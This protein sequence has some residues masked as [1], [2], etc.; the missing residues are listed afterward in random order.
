MSDRTTTGRTARAGHRAGRPT[1]RPVGRS[2]GQSGTGRGAGPAGNSPWAG[3]REKWRRLL[4]SPQ[5][6]YK[7]ILLVTGL[8]VVIGLIVALSSSMVT[9]R[10]QEGGTVF[11]EFV[12]QARMVLIGLVVMWGALWVRP[13]KVRTWAPVL[14]FVAVFFLVLVLVIGVGDEI[15]SRSWIALGPLSF[16]PSEI[17]KLALAVWG[18]AAVALHSRQSP[19]VAGGL[20]AFIIVSGV[21]IGLVLAQKDLGMMFSLA[22]PLLALLLF[23]GAS[24]RIFGAIFGVLALLGAFSI[25]NMGYRSDRISTWLDAL[26]MDFSGEAGQGAAF[27]AKQGMFSLSDGGLIGQGLGQSR[28]KWNYLP[29]ATNDFVFA[30]V[31]EEIGLLG[32]GLVIVLFALLGWF[33]MRTA[34]HQTDPFLRL[35]AA[36]LTVGIVGQAFYNIGYVCG[37]F[38]VT[39]V[40]L[41]LLSAGGTSAVITL[42][43]LGL[44]ANCARHEPETVSSMQHEGRPLIDRL[45]MLREPTVPNPG[46]E[47]R[48]Q[49]RPQTRR[50][51]D[52]VTHRPAPR[53]A[54]LDGRRGRP[55]ERVD[56][57]PRRRADGYGETPERGRPDHRRSGP[58]GSDVRRSTEDRPGRRGAPTDDHRSAERRRR[59]HP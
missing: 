38:P 28:A 48:E 13:A 39:G 19:T 49:V 50:Y 34:T 22:L 27:Q 37:L 51:G 5:L 20:K 58:R 8:L 6:D 30:I 15:G 33:G 31:G 44:L 23:S 52:P 17:A 47:H 54:D 42:G 59:Y 18:S 46:A 4:A 35:L 10:S 1:G 2:T 21:V 45:L 24:T 55:G 29:E 11:S 43:T 56:A 32:A 36:T 7:V 41:P 26:R 9:S 53:S 40:Q 16:Q 14:L 57:R 12:K 25:V 3:L